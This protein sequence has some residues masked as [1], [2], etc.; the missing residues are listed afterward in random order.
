MQDQEHNTAVVLFLLI[1]VLGAHN[2]KQWGCM[3]TQED[4]LVRALHHLPNCYQPTIS[5]IGWHLRTIQNL[6]EDFFHDDKDFIKYLRYISKI[7]FSH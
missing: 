1:A 5:Y 7:Y 2:G 6:G 3:R 4:E